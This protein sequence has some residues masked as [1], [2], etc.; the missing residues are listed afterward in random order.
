MPALDPK[1]LLALVILAGCGSGVMLL[2]LLS[3]RGRDLALF[4][5]VFA[6]PA[7]EMMK[8]TFFG[9]FWYRGTSRGIEL[10]ALDLV[11]FCLLC[12][13]LLAPRERPARPYW[14]PSFA[15]MLTYFAYCAGSVCTA[16]FSLPGIWELVKML[17]G[18][19]VFLVAAF[20]IRTRRDLGIV[21]AALGCAVT[22]QTIVALQQR[23]IIGQ[24]RASGTF[25]HENTLSTYLCM[26]APVL[27]A[28]AMSRWPVW[29]RW[30]A[31]LSWVC[32][33]GTEMLTLSRLGVPVFACVSIATVL[34]CTW[35]VARP[36]RALLLLMAAVVGVFVASSW[37][38]LKARYAARSLK[39][40]FTDQRGFETRGVYWRLA[41]AMVNDHPFG[42]GLNNW[43]YVVGKDYARR[44]GYPYRDYDTVHDVPEGDSS[45]LFAPAADSLPALTL[46]ELGVAGFLLLL[47]L[48]LRWMQ[49]GAVFLTARG[50]DDPPQRI[51]IGFFFGALGIFLQSATEWTYRQPPVMY[52]FL[53]LAAMA[54]SLYRLRGVVPEFADVVSD[55]ASA[56]DLAALRLARIVK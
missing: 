19:L 39:A 30:F 10:S 49:L 37:D 34:A 4:L 26:V 55:D 7:M 11:A 45:S 36:R 9:L 2:T 27:L 47:A 54:A 3:Q 32:A 38:G 50:N 12:A 20:A 31:G 16:N 42:V 56:A 53:V 51:A 15:L 5:L 40:E 43:S 22:V 41:V 35:R 13:T 46:G 52:T 18:L 8:V 25:D 6:A 23:F 33:A 21:V 17:R 44:F 28:A 1:H 24:F 29:L 48:W 14:P